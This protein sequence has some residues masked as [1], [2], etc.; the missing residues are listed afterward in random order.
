MSFWSDIGDAVS[1]AADAVGDALSGIPVVGGALNAVFHWVGDVVSGVTDFV[2]AVIKGV[3]GIVGG[4]ICGSIRVI[5]GGIGGLLNGDSSVFVKGLIDIGSGIAGS[6]LTTTGKFIGLV[7][8]IIPLQW[9]KRPLTEKENEILRRVF[10]RSVALYNVRIIEGS[11]GIF[12]I[13]DYPFTLGNTIYL[14][15]YDPAAN[16]EALVHECAHVW[17]YQNNGVA[18]YRRRARGAVLRGRRI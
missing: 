2:G 5:G 18:L 1:D 8:S 9:G 4:V 14:K 3:S 13:N 7:Q 11:A 12:S 6:F 10:R 16:P 15:D 17:Q